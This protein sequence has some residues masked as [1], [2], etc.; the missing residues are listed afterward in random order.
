M[1][2]Y[3]LERGVRA[4]HTQMSENRVLTRRQLDRW[5]LVSS[6]FFFFEFIFY[7]KFVFNQNLILRLSFM[8]MLY[9]YFFFG[10]C[11]SC[12]DTSHLLMRSSSI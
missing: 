4:T 7:V 2:I 8:L 3:G 12:L 5:F 6:S 11:V 10:I 1:L 9:S